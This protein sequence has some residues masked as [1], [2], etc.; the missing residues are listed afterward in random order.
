MLPFPVP[1]GSSRTT[2]EKEYDHL[3]LN[4]FVSRKNTGVVY[5]QIEGNSMID[6]QIFDGDIAVVDRTAEPRSGDVIIARIGDDYTVKKYERTRECLY[7]VPANHRYKREEITEE[8]D[9]EIF[10]VVTWVIH[11][12]R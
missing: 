6:E 12:R 10:G 11:R 4:E 7:L 2:G 9:F 5:V 1:A 3:D 8:D